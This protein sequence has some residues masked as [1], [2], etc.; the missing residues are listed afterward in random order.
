LPHT[1]IGHGIQDV[2]QGQNYIYSTTKPYK[3]IVD[4]AT[5]SSATLDHRI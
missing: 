2:Y 3:N 5:S 1:H 4:L